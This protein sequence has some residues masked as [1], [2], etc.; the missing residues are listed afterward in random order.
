MFNNCKTSIY[1]Y[2][3]LLLIYLKTI[4]KNAFPVVYPLVECLYNLCRCWWSEG[5]IVQSCAEVLDDPI[6]FTFI[7][8][9]VHVPVWCCFKEIW[10]SKKKMKLKT[11]IWQSFKKITQKL[12]TTC[13]EEEL[14]ISKAVTRREEVQNSNGRCQ[15]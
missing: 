11:T 6:Y 12:R 7:N 1:K 2:I 9:I 13:K 10:R 5:R 3:S 14:V 8:R 4:K 15:Q